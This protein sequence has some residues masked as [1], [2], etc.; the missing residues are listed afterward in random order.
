VTWPSQGA[1]CVKAKAYQE[2]HLRISKTIAK[3]FSHKVAL[4]S[5]KEDWANDLNRHNTGGT[6]LDHAQ[7]SNAL[8]ELVDL[9][10]LDAHSNLMYVEFLRML[11]LNI[12]LSYR[13]KGFTDP[14]SRLRPVDET[15]C[16]ASSMDN[17]RD[18]LTIQY[19]S[20]LSASVILNRPDLI[21]LYV[22]FTR[23]MY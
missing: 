5:A 18:Q 14:I 17:M 15:A 6:S 23:D 2:L 12:T 11:F 16:L 19:L 4:R 1:T 21:R 7:F 9:W 22:N 13:K 10:C 3:G 20:I 8:F